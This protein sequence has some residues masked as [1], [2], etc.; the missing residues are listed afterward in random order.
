MVLRRVALT[1]AS[2]MLGRYV[3]AALASRQISAVAVSRSRPKVL[4]PNAKWQAWDLNHARTEDELDGMF[5]G[6]DALLHVADEE[7]RRDALLR[8]ANDGRRGLRVEVSD[9]DQDGD[10][11]VG[12]EAF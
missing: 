8:I 7:D 2:G 10:G 11:Q 3:L 6:V 9:L 1:G 4:E 5:S 12:G